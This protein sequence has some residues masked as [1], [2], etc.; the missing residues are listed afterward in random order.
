MSGIRLYQAFTWV[1]TA[2]DWFAKITRRLAQKMAR[3]FLS[4]SA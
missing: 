1:S 2:A 3:G 4:K